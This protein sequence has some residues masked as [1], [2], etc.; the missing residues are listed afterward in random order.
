M[1]SVCSN[2]RVSV[3]NDDGLRFQFT[4]PSLGW[5][6]TEEA[7]RRLAE[8]VSADPLHQRHGPWHV[9]DVDITA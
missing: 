1:R 2:F 5:L 7:E 3:V 8:I 6:S 9:R 4:M